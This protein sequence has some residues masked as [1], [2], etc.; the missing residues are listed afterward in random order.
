M[1]ETKAELSKQQLIDAVS[2]L[3][4]FVSAF[5][6][7]SSRTIAT[8]ELED[9]ADS[10]IALEVMAADGVW[11]PL[12][13]VPMWTCLSQPL[14][15]KLRQFPLFRVAWYGQPGPPTLKPHAGIPE[16]DTFVGSDETR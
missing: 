5:G 8:A 9:G 10:H 1:R 15:G 13:I 4:S 12:A 2:N 16:Q 3:S 11:S 6:A 14:R 7:H